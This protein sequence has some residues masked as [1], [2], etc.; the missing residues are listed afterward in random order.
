MHYTGTIHKVKSPAEGNE[1]Q[2]SKTEAVDKVKNG[3]S[4][5]LKGWN[6]VFPPI[7]RVLST[8]E[9]EREK[10]ATKEAVRLHCEMNLSITPNI[11]RMDDHTS[12]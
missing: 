11:Y 7:A 9:K 3:M 12:M 8:L 4:N 10:T 2:L 1:A 6:R 5:L